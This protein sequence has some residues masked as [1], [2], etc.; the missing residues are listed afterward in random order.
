[1]SSYRPKVARPYQFK[2]GFCV[3]EHNSRAKA[4][5]SGWMVEYIVVVI[6]YFLFFILNNETTFCKLNWAS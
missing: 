5:Q 3:F 4:N 2:N 1:M 6:K